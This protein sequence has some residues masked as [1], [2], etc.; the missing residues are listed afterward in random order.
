MLIINLHAVSDEPPNS[1]DAANDSSWVAQR[2]VVIDLLS[3]LTTRGY[4]P[5]LPIP[6][7]SI[8]DGQTLH[9]P[10]ARQPIHP[11][12]GPDPF[13]LRIAMTFDDVRDGSFQLAMEAGNRFGMAS[14]FFPVPAFLDGAAIPAVERY[15][16][17]LS[18]D[19]LGQL[20]A[21]GHV[22]GSHGLTHRPLDELTPQELEKE[23]AGSKARI[24]SRLG[25][26]VTTLSLPH[27]RTSR[28][29]CEAASRFGYEQIYNSYRGWNKPFTGVERLRR[30]DVR[31][32]DTVQTLMREIEWFEQSRQFFDVL[33]VQDA[34]PRTLSTEEMRR[35][36]FFDLVVTRSKSLFDQLDQG[37]FE[38]LLSDSV[39]PTSE[40]EGTI[41]AII[42]EKIS[43][44]PPGSNT[45]AN[46]VRPRFHEHPLSAL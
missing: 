27:G 22:V 32:Y 35:L 17:F 15:S 23:L 29:V 46:E 4:R 31:S 6:L 24:E 19:Q 34:D 11:T 39:R 7:R 30:L 14:L 12:T 5:A 9:R 38:P 3:H 33:L 28:C 18:W 1:A 44:M 20:I 45:F 42:V 40:L 41:N 10:G 2:T 13:A 16:D 25:N 21:A 36:G 26:S 37:G 43:R 8:P